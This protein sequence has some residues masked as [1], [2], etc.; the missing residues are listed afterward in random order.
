M[1]I[2]TV[3]TCFQCPFCIPGRCTEDEVSYNGYKCRKTG[4]ILTDE[5]NSIDM[6]CELDEVSDDAF[7]MLAMLK[8]TFLDIE[9]ELAYADKDDDLEEDK[10]IYNFLRDACGF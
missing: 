4:A 10:I 5:R 1:R 6:D 8:Q 3:H 9:E 2:V 7:N